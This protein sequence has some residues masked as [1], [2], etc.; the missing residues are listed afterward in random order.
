MTKQDNK[1]LTPLTGDQIR[2]FGHLLEGYQR[3]LCCVEN[4]LK[5]DSGMA[6][7]ELEV[8]IRL[9][10]EPEEK[11]RPS[12]LADKCVMSN[13]GCTRLLDRLEEKKY[14]KRTQHGIDRRGL[15]VELTKRGKQ[16]LESVLP[17]HYLSLEENLWSVLTKT[18]L[19][20]LSKIMQKV[21]DANSD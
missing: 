19:D 1:V 4:D 5:T 3:L 15:V 13:S 17:N 2:A 9:T 6:I 21:R 7:Q 14:I 18:E 10:N 11:L 20:S 8:L 16:K 12:D